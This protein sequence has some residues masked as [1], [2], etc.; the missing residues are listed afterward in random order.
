MNQDE[1]IERKEIPKE[2]LRNIFGLMKEVYD[3]F[4]IEISKKSP[5]S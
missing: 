1:F 2:M 3:Y 5:S 4:K